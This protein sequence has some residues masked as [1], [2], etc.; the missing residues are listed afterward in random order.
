VFFTGDAAHVFNECWKPLL[1]TVLTDLDAQLATCYDVIGVLVMTR[2][3][4]HAQLQMAHA[5]VSLAARVLHHTCGTHAH[6][7]PAAMKDCAM[8]GCKHRNHTYWQ[9]AASAT[10]ALNDAN[11]TRWARASDVP[12]LSGALMFEPAGGLCRPPGM[13]RR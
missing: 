11:H 7:P 3:V 5:Q 12:K 1:A 9:I 8:V 10:H 4:S 2:I 13:Q 6:Q